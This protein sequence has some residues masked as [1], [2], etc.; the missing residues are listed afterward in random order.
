MPNHDLTRP[1]VSPVFILVTALIASF[2]FNGKNLFAFFVAQACLVLALVACLYFAYR[3][4]TKIACTMVT[5]FVAF[6]V[7]WL[8]LPILWSKIPYLSVITAW[9]LS[10]FALAYFIIILSPERKFPYSAFLLTACIAGGLQGLL[11][12]YQ[13][14]VL[15]SLPNGLFLYQ[16][17]LGG[18]LS[19]QV[20]VL[21]G[22]FLVLAE[23]DRRR[24]F[25][26]LPLLF[27]LAF[28]LGFLQSRGVI[29][30]FSLGMVFFL[31]TALYL[32]TDRRLLF[33]LV[34]TFLLA[35]I[36]A[37]ATTLSGMSQ[38]IMTIENPYNA[39]KSRFVIWQGCFQMIRDYPLWGNG[40]GTYWLLWPPYRAPSDT[41]GGYFAHNDYLQFW[42]EGG[43][44]LIILLLALMCAM[45]VS[46]FRTI[47]S[48]D[49]ERA[50]KIEAL[51]IFAGLIALAIHTVFD[52]NFYT[53]PIMILAGAMLGRFDTLNPLGKR[54]FTLSRMRLRPSL[55]AACLLL[56]SVMVLAHFL[57][58]GLSYYYCEKGNGLAAQMRFAE[59]A[60]SLE[61]AEKLWTAYDKPLYSHAHLLGSLIRAKGS[62]GMNE[63]SRR[64][65][66]IRAKENLEKAER[67]NPYR[68]QTYVIRG[69]LEESVGG[70][71]SDV[72]EAYRTALR[73]DPRYFPAR[74]E[75]GRYL[76]QSGQGVA[77]LAVLEEGMVHY[78]P[79][80]PALIPYY[81]LTSVLRRQNGDEKGARVLE[82]KISELEE[83]S[84]KERSEKKPSLFF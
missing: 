5:V 71:R 2:F 40:L 84:R 37:E 30:S 62:D 17:L 24:G 11:A 15:E 72:M 77:A 10:A 51:S 26:L 59:A 54:Y 14:F 60:A 50:T 39:G 70:D 38:R 49:P 16:N 41:S 68:P 9:W 13:F 35:F 45:A 8:F 48:P 64:V 75:Y 61:K 79:D 42:I 63:E 76:S 4:Q 31:G 22:L 12:L 83:K 46:F 58:M 18:F 67:V 6:M 73:I 78:Y 52:F 20:F 21:S 3:D 1:A 19:L 81:Q 33:I 34:V 23:K 27:F 82:A 80:D 65:L 56:V 47:T 28:M 57:F 44:P 29:L 43:L 36:S 53:M 69:L 66:C 7:L 55:F 25:L 32:K 74:V